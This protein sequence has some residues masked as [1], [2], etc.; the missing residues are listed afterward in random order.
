MKTIIKT[1]LLAVALL[2]GISA[3]AQD[4][5]L[6][7][8]VKAGMNLS[9]MTQDLKGDAKVGFNVGLT[10]DYNLTPDVYLLTGIDYSLEGTKEGNRKVNMSYLK[11][12]VHVG[13]KVNVTENTKI[14]LHAG[15]YVGYAISG[16]YK[17]GGIS[18][19]AFDDEIASTLGYKL[20]RFDFGL[21]LGVGAEFGQI[22]VGLGYDLGLVNLMDIKN[23]SRIEE[24]IGESIGSVKGKNMNAYLTV[25]YKF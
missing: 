13:Y 12:P 22:C 17:E 18:I 4:K 23:R 2:I 16:K 7:F 11:L 24:I 8:G 3:N 21:G 9:N 6:T 19:D 1:G 5:P 14:V 15:P 20:K 10:M 25:G